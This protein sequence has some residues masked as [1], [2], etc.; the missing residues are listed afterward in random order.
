MNKSELTI[1]TDAARGILLGYLAA[2]PEPLYLAWRAGMVV[3]VTHPAIA[4]A[5]TLLQTLIPRM[6]QRDGGGGSSAVVLAPQAVA[7]ALRYLPQVQVVGLDAVL[8]EAEALED[9]LV[10]RG[11]VV[12]ALPPGLV[13]TQ[14]MRTVWPWLTQVMGR[15]LTPPC[16][17]TWDDPAPLTI[18]RAT[19]QLAIHT[20]PTPPIIGA[21]ATLVADGDGWLL[22]L[23]GTRQPQRLL[24]DAPLRV[25][26]PVLA[27]V[28][29]R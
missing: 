25:P 1:L 21:H 29:S 28:R 20:R 11:T 24:L 12:V 22:T 19:T 9:L 26:L 6:M 27:A 2:Y 16:L 10:G 8:T 14:L 15:L 5:T 18:A 7:E 4:D 3:Q 23:V 17:V 13:T